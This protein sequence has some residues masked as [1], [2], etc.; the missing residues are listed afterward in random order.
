MKR[1]PRSIHGQFIKARRLLRAG[2]HLVREA[3][4]RLGIAR[5]RRQFDDVTGDWD[6]AYG[7]G[8]HDHYRAFGERPRYGV[9][10]GY[11]GAGDQPVSILDVG[12]GVGLFCRDIPDE[13][14]TRFVG[15]DPAE[16][17]VR[18]ANR[19]GWQRSEFLVGTVPDST[20]GKFDII[21]LLGTLTQLTRSPREPSGVTD[22]GGG[23]FVLIL[24]PRQGVARVSSPGAGRGSGIAPC[25]AAT[26][27][28][29]INPRGCYFTLARRV[30]PPRRV[31]PAK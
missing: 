2:Q 14:I 24:L 26:S 20:L 25:P 4:I 23:Y 11:V 30:P 7:S 5:Y 17:A 22:C 27:Q 9:L 31:S 21:A 3:A 28:E 19:Q 8:E 18:E 29:G 15:I 6:E 12:C 1:G 10:H 16:V 13:R